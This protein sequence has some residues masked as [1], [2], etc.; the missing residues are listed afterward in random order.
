MPAS[1]STSQDPAFSLQPSEQCARIVTGSCQ[2]G[3][4]KRSEAQALMRAAYPLEV[5]GGEGRP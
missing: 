5:A 2:R 1:D 4:Q 3:D